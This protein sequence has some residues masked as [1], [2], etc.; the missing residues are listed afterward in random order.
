M[1]EFFGKTKDGVVVDQ[2]SLQNKGGMIVKFLNFGCRLTSILL[3]YG[4]GHADVLLGYDT[5][6]GYEKDYS[7]QGAVV[8]RY[9]N[10]IKN[11][12]F[13]LNGNEYRLMKNDGENYLHGSLQ[14]HVFTAKESSENSVV[15]STLSPAGEDGFPGTLEIVL[16]FTLDDDNRFTMEYF[17]KTDADTYVNL[18]SHPYF[19]LSAGD[20]E[21]IENQGLWLNS[22][23]FLEA[24]K[25]L[26]PTGRLVDVD[27]GPFDFS[28]KK[29]IGRDIASND[30]QI[31]RAGGYDHS[32]LVGEG[33]SEKLALIAEASDKLEKRKLKIF[34]TQPAVHFYT[35]NV[36]NGSTTGKGRV[37]SR[38][39]G[40]CLETQHY[41]DSPNHPE[42]P[43]TLLRP[44]EEYSETTALQFEY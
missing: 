19:D 21:N 29:N 43:N 3:P 5:V 31:K 36:L 14:N 17:A 24:G 13:S 42:F 35:G 10:R 41:P 39:S 26:V 22:R 11:A 44:G 15:L 40:F 8:G 27:G 37:I 33:R 7:N 34:T 4:A 25:D 30:E 18:T 6:E 28:R 1:R 23:R 16:T 9:A 2:Y 38:R 20:D 32:F 12:V